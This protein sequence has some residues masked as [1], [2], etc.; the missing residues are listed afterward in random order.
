MS[1]VTRD[2]ND[3][4]IK[5]K[6]TNETITI[7]GWFVSDANKIEQVRLTNVWGQQ[8]VW[9]AATLESMTAVVNHAPVAIADTKAV[10]EDVSVSTTAA[11]GVLANDTDADAGDTKTVAAV[12]FGGASG[13]V[14]AALNGTYG[15]LTLKADGSYT[16]LANKAAAE[17]LKPG[18]SAT[19]S[20]NYTVKDTAGAASSS[21]LSFT[22][23]G[24][25]DGPV[26]VADTKAVT[27]DVS[28]TATASTGVLANDTDVDSGDSK[29]VSAVRFGSTTG[30]VGSALAG[31]YGT[32]TLNADGSYSYLA[33]KTAAQALAVGQSASE[34]FSYTVKDAA[35]ATSSSTLSFTITGANDAPVLAAA[36]SSQ[37]GKEGTAFSY[38]LPAGTFA[39]VN[40]SEVL[41]YSAK[42]S[43]GSA[44]PSWLS[45]NATTGVFSGT[46]TTGSAGTVAIVVT[47]TDKAGATATGSFSIVIG[48]SNHAPV[49]V[50]DTKA[51]TEDVSVTATASTGVLANDTDVDS[52][53]S[54]SVSAVSFGST[55]GTVGSAL[56]G[57]YGTLTLNA[58]GSY[59]YL[60]NKTAAQAL[61]A[62]QSAS[63]SFNYTVKDTAGATSSSTLSFTISG[64]NDGPVAVADTKAVTEDV[65]VTATASTGVLANDTDVD[66]G[67]SKTV[68]AVSFGS[69]TG[70]V[71]SAL[72]GTYG[73]LTLNADGSYS[74]LANKTA[75]QALA[76]G[77]S[78]SES[79]SYTVKDAA[80]A[81]SS[82]TLSF[83]ITG[84]NDAPVL[85]AAISSQSGKEGTAFSYTLP[86]GTF[87]D[88]NASEVLTYSAK[89]SNGSALPSWLSFNATT[90]VFSGTPG[91]GSAGTVAI[92]VTAT[93]KAG[94]TATG[95]FNIV[96]ASG[97][98]VVNGTSGAD[99][100][101][102]TSGDDQINGLAGNDKLTGSAGNDTLDGGT[103]NDSML[104]GAGNDIYVVDST[105][106]VVTENSGEGTDL[107][108]SSVAWSLGSNVENLTL[109]GS[110]AISGTGNSLG[111]VIA[112]N[113]AA[114]TLDGSS[115]ADTL[116]GGAGNDLYI[117]DNAGDIVTENASEG[118]DT[119]QSSVTYTLGSNV[120]NLTLTGS[121]ALS[122]TGN[123]LDNVL[124]GN[125][126]ANAL[127]GAAGNDT[128]DGGAGN[129]SML[130]GSG[131]D[132]YVVDSTS[133]VVTENSNEGT[134][135]V[136]ASVT[137][138]LGNN[139]EN[140]T[141]TGTT[142]ING[143]GNALDNLLTGNSAANKLTGAA[144]NDTLD[145]GS[146]ND[147][148][149]GGAGN[150]IYVVDSTS[151]VVT[152]NSSE[153]T[154]LVKASVTWTLGSNVENL[155]L[156]GTTA[157]NGTGN[158][159][160]NVLTG[161][162]AANTL[163]GAAGSDTLDG[164][165]GN[166]SLIGGAGNDT[167]MLGRGY[168][169]DTITENDSTSGNTDVLQAASDIAAAQLWFVKNGNNLE[170]SVIGTSDKNIL[171]NWYLG[172]QYHVE[173][174]KS[175]DGKTLLD[176]QVQ[177]LVSAMAAFSPP[178]AGQ[179]TLPASYQATLNSVIAANWK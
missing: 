43:N 149:L 16:Y 93:D 175:G 123:T 150:D 70:T 60:A 178:A 135:L 10:T 61:A 145:G 77:Q 148:M 174:F 176:T 59:S 104:G 137:W 167:Y 81:T 4:L 153:G 169:I 38:T 62:G 22:I 156:T 125:S 13:T 166:D 44:L 9:D 6:A 68:S 95:S 5:L 82:S 122:G 146:G 27:E 35:G 3:L 58:D 18:Q 36:I 90:G 105:S 136:K 147:S 65:S 124:T 19:E 73:T 75:A 56:A 127:T 49:A 8:V 128:L 130:G 139:V 114:N 102:G 28:V 157:I 24:A 79:F 42:L 119:V 168:G 98:S 15:T 12:G 87:A 133:D 162:S 106:D 159:L 85:A 165:A 173:Q 80:G 21:T 54:K 121:S 14:G 103:G 117:V 160:N 115:G 66:S 110:N 41:T 129:D 76:V 88:V 45:F 89:L 83:T 53:D 100:L 20:F 1:N 107:V 140:L 37:S 172:S 144:G 171:T 108:Q 142:A 7:D 170:V 138:T 143:T 72:A 78:A 141:L 30:S 154:D 46:P 86:A 39:D 158:T 55:T 132:T 164:G 101:T 47:A 161:N 118:S 31:T 134:D 94:A 51:V 71:G 57:S 11:T 40:A 17:A 120:E 152:E 67:D 34:S 23:S 50:A 96:I 151:D 179:T 97:L 126:A 155:T 69:T 109:T 92:V 63:E 74:Y 32:L 25:N 116:L 2:G 84:A 29:T 64:A 163:T 26:A 111:N 113:A 177:S 131:N 99:T 48:T 33:N 91:I 52:G 112:G